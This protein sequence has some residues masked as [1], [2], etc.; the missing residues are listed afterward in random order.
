MKNPL[1]RYLFCSFLLCCI[2]TTAFAQETG[3][4]FGPETKLS[5]VWGFDLKTDSILED[6]GTSAAIYGGVLV[7]SAITIALTGSFNVGHDVVNFGY[8][9]LLTQ[10]TLNPQKVVHFSGQLLLGTGSAKDYMQEKTSTFDNMGNISG[11]GFF[12]V[13][14][15]FNVEFN[16]TEKARLV[17]GLSYRLVS[18]LNEDSTLIARSE[19]KN[20]DLSGIFFNL[21]VKVGIY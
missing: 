2:C 17:A 21:G 16:L 9:G 3:T 1:I 12:F 5:S 19:I 20:K 4:I 13:E 15:G 11:P 10:Y 14:P 6:V 8:L 7:N 18:G